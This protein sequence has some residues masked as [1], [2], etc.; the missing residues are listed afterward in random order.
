ML[1][2][3][4]NDEKETAG[5]YFVKYRVVT[6]KDKVFYLYAD[7]PYLLVQGLEPGV[8]YVDYFESKYIRSG[9]QMTD[10]DEY[11][12][13]EIEAD[14]ITILEDWLRVRLYK[15][16]G[17]RYQQS[18]FEYIPAVEKQKLKEQFENDN[19]MGYWQFAD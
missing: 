19:D 1:L 9:R 11:I 14:K 8:H 4:V 7:K 17:T 10:R 2:V 6:N 12:Q 5:D 15:K 3:A 18:K 13:F 16:D